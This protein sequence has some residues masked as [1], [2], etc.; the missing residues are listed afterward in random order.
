MNHS[1]IGFKMAIAHVSFSGEDSSHVSTQK[2]GCAP[3]VGVKTFQHFSLFFYAE[4]KHVHNK[5]R[6]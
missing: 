2:Y 1:P 3:L 6:R 4:T 5:V